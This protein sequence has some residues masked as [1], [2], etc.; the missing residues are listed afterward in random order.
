MERKEDQ[1]RRETNI[2]LHNIPESRSENPNA[3]KQYDSDSFDNIVQ[4]LLE[5]ETIPVDKIFRLGKKREQPQIPI[6]NK[7]LVKWNVCTQINHSGVRH[8]NESNTPKGVKNIP[9]KG[10]DTL[11]T[12][13]QVLSFI[14]AER[15]GCPTLLKVSHWHLQRSWHQKQCTGK[16]LVWRAIDRWV[17]PPGSVRR[18]WST[19]ATVAI[20]N[21]ASAW[22]ADSWREQGPKT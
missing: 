5:N 4:A 22:V 20:G 16:V 18:R 15:L 10:Y 8:P 3:R 2:I 9:K 1:E 19:I 21:V 12:P 13:F 11:T 17:S 14:A 7:K 6:K